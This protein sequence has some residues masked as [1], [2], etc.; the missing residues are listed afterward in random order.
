[1]D[2]T[3]IKRRQ[4]RSDPAVPVTVGVGHTSTLVSEGLEAML[5]RMPGC[6]LRL[7]RFSP[8]ACA[9]DCPPP[10]QLIFGDSALLQHVKEKSKCSSECPAA[11][12]KF[13]WVTTGDDSVAHASK[14]AGEVDECLS[15]EC[16]EEEL[17]AIVERLIDFEEARSRPATSFA[18][19]AARASL[20]GRSSASS[21]PGVNDPA[22]I[23]STSPTRPKVRGGLAPGALRRVREHVE[24]HLTDKILSET[25]AEVAGL[26]GGHFNRAFK[27]SIGS[28]P[29]QYVTQRRV[30]AATEL[31]EKSNRS[32]ADIALDVGFADQSH[33]C[34]TYVAQTGETPSVCR[35]RHR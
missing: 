35:R 3:L 30:A 22:V 28:S 10:A 17:Y 15:V 29:H 12:A 4:N 19:R 1:M 25:L 27:Q 13:V 32:L 26:S 6:E 33:F 23:A 9:S 16:P 7:W 20:K 14:A 11:K 21:R 8:T 2:S 34:R 31:L 18:D 5:A 24:Q